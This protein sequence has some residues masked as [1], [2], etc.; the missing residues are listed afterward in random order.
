MQMNE[1]REMNGTLERVLVSIST[2]RPD[3]KRPLLGLPFRFERSLCAI[4]AGGIAEPGDVILRFGSPHEVFRAIAPAWKKS[5]SPGPGKMIFYHF[6]EFSLNPTV[7]PPLMAKRFRKN[8]RGKAF[9]GRAGI[10]FRTRDLNT[11]H[12]WGTCRVTEIILKCISNY[13]PY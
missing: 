13:Y 9:P 2:L 3:G 6:H 7:N 8:H 1:I 5:A 4:T 12:G 10:S 11:P